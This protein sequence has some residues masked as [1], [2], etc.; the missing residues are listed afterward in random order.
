MLK[1]QRTL[2]K[3]INFEGIGLHTGYS[4]KLT[5]VPAPPDTGIRFRR[6]PRK[7]QSSAS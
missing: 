2:R 5:L 7:G 4:V 3:E 6:T 1:Y